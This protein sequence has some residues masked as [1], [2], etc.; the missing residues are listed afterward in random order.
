MKGFSARLAAASFV[1]VA[2]AMM[3]GAA[4]AATVTTFCPGT[5]A[6]NDR[7]FTVTT[8]APGATCIAYGSGNISG[9]SAGANPDPLFGILG[10]SYQLIGKSDSTP[11]IVSVTGV[12][13]LTGTWAL[14]LPAAP[15]GMMWTNLVLALKSGVAQLNPD[16]AAFGLPNGVTSGTWSIAN[17]RQSLSHANLYGELAPIPVPAAGLLLLGGL[18]ALAAMRR[19]RRA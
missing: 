12:G 6:T 4:G 3:A 10:A 2:V 1:A 8:V 11:S 7:E 17:G 13:A 5:V 14:F 18:G 16:W 9:N 19:R 15:T